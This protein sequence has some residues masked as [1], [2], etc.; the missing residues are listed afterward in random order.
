MLIKS[1]I[2]YLN[3]IILLISDEQELFDLIQSELKISD[4]EL[5]DVLSSTVTDIIE[6]D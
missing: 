4:T 6:N 5:D 3:E 1:K 2:E